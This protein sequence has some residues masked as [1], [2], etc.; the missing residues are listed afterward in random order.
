MNLPDEQYQSLV[1][2][3]RSLPLINVG[4]GKDLTIRELVE[5]VKAVVGYEWEITWDQTKPD[6]SPESY[7]M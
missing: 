7:L 2:D 3:H 6:G 5:L 1:A 4:V